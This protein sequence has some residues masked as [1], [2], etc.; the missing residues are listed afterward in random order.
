M[1]AEAAGR[2]GPWSNSVKLVQPT[3]S[4]AHHVVTA[5]ADGSE[6][7]RVHIAMLNLCAARSDMTSLLSV[8]AGYDSERAAAYV[9]E[10]SAAF[11]AGEIG[12][13]GLEP[14]TPLGRG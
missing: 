2:F 3:G 6:A 14:S 13:S 11:G 12:R 10:L 5:I 7:R 9:A 4:S 8:P 1:R